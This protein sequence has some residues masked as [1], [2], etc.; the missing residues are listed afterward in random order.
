MPV[1]IDFVDPKQR[2]LKSIEVRSIERISDVWTARRIVAT[3]HQTGHTTEF[4]VRDIDYEETLD[5]GLFNP[6]ALGRGLGAAL[7]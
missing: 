3:N 4:A 7:K 2:P 6:Q 1:R 5:E